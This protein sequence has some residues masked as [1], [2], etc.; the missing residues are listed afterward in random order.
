MPGD[1]VQR[2]RERVGE[3]GEF[4][5]HRLG[6]RVQHAVVRR[7]QF[8]VAAGHVRR[9]PG[10]NAR[11]DVAVG[12]TP[13]QAV[14]TVF[15]CGT[16]RFDTARP[17][18]QPRV[19]HDALSDVDTPCLGTHRHHVGDHF[20]THHLRERAERRHRVVGVSFP[21]VEQDLFGIRA[22]NTR[23]PWPGDHPIIVQRLRIGHVHQCDGA[24]GQILGEWVGILGHIERLTRHT[25]DQCPHGRAIAAAPA[26]KASISAF[27]ASTTALRS[28]T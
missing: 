4:V 19:E 10:V 14:V 20:V 12:E 11:L 3:D 23:Q 8:G 6:H 2:H 13:A 25:E 16:R 21:E 5:G 1:R 18:R 7:H 22:A 27:L 26:T 15:A 9:H 17:A 28:G 24:A